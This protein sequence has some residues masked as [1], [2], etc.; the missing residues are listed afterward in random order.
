ME[1]VTPRPRGLIRGN[2]RLSLDEPQLTEAHLRT[3]KAFSTITRLKNK[4]LAL[5]LIKTNGVSLINQTKILPK[6]QQNPVCNETYP[7]P[8]N[9]NKTFNLN[10]SIPQ[11]D[12]QAVK[13]HKSY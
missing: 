8:R 3:R 9:I 1:R 6:I 7:L 12:T 13:N 5:P 2:R 10:P 11:W 4:T